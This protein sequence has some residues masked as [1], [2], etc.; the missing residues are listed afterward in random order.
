MV[1][2]VASAAAAAAATTA[3]FV[4][5]ANEF[6]KVAWDSLKVTKNA[7]HGGRF[8]VINRGVIPHHLLCIAIGW[9]DQVW[10]AFGTFPNEDSGKQQCSPPSVA[11]STIAAATETQAVLRRGCKVGPLA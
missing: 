3:L 1:A 8:L 11:S 7:V 2:P 6:H 9:L 4:T 10:R 5:S